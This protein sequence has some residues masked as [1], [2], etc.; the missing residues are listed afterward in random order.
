MMGGRNEL[1]AMYKSSPDP[2][3]REAVI[4]GMMMCGDVQGLIEIASTEK[5]PQVLDK[6]INTLGMVG[7]E[8]SLT[9]LTNIYN[10]HNDLPTKK[11]VINAMFLH[12]AAKEMVALARKETNP[13]LKKAWMQKLSLMRSPEITEYMMEIL[14]K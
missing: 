10:S 1:R 11:R 12:G 7:G 5:D 13:E 9:A 6:A 2:A 14:N 8:E 4:N 3:T